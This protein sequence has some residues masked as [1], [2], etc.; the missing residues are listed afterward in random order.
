MPK[1]NEF[2]NNSMNSSSALVAPRRSEIR[3]SFSIEYPSISDSTRKKL[4]RAAM[5]LTPVLCAV[6]AVC[7][8]LGLQLPWWAVALAV[9]ATSVG[10]GYGFLYIV[11]M[12]EKFEHEQQK[13]G[14]K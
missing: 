5:I 12:A 14:R 13:G 6:L 7:H 10:F 2:T 9:I 1:N 11:A 3:V 4:H 8:A